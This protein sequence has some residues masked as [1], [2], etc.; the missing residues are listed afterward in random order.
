MQETGLQKLKPQVIMWNWSAITIRHTHM[1]VIKQFRVKAMM[2]GET[3]RHKS[4]SIL[5]VMIFIFVYDDFYLCVCVCVWD[6]QKLKHTHMIIFK[7][8]SLSI[9]L[10]LYWYIILGVIL[11]SRSGTVPPKVSKIV[12]FVCVLIKWCVS[13]DKMSVKYCKMCIVL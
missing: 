1:I 3:H 8:L 2:H 7:Q 5:C 11:R 6:L 13:L 10:D 12:I 4:I 9:E